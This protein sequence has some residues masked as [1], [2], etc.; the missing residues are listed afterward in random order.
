M[1]VPA[2]VTHDEDEFELFLQ[3]EETLEKSNVWA[4]RPVVFSQTEAVRPLEEAVAQ[5][6]EARH[7]RSVERCP[8]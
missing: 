4:A 8:S 2:S 7:L 5:L 6:E 3:S 1:S